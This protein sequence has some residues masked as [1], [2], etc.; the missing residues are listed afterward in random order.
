MNTQ[1]HATGDKH[2][3]S[4]TL[5]LAKKLGANIQNRALITL[6][7]K[8]P[9]RLED[10]IAA[11]EEAT[12]RGKVIYPTGHLIRAIQDSWQPEDGSRRERTEFSAWFNDMHSRG[13]VLGSE[14]PP[15]GRIRI[16]ASNGSVHF[17]DELKS[18]CGHEL[19]RLLT[20]PLIES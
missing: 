13:L 17:Y 12:N 15:K 20:K 18:L 5:Q 2:S 14:R 10:A 16:F 4:A 19:D 8:H 11:L 6:A 9:E 3:A 7:Q 1:Q